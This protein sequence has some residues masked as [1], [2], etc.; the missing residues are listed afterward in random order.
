MILDL[1]FLKIDIFHMSLDLCRFYLVDYVMSLMFLDLCLVDGVVV[2]KVNF[3]YIEMEENT[4][5]FDEAQDATA[6]LKSK[7]TLLSLFFSLV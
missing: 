6:C 7:K 4:M 5:C 3:E 1:S 2:L